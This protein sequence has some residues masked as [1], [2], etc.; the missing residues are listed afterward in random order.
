MDFL[1]SIMAFAR[2][3]QICYFLKIWF[4][5]PMHYNGLQWSISLL[6]NPLYYIGNCLVP[7]LALYRQLVPFWFAQISVNPNMCTALPLWY[8]TPLNLTDLNFFKSHLVQWVNT[9]NISD[10]FFLVEKNILI[11]FVIQTC[12]KIAL[13]MK[14]FDIKLFQAFLLAISPLDCKAVQSGQLCVIPFRF[15]NWQERETYLQWV[16]T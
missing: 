16:P 7:T 8:S 13:F 4:Q 2:A 5:F 11:R 6:C 1:V 3:E 15:P 14:I 12:W 10:C 9:R